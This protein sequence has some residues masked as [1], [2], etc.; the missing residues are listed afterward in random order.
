MRLCAS[1]FYARSVIRDRR[2]WTGH[3]IFSNASWVVIGAIGILYTVWAHGQGER[4]DAPSRSLG[5]VL[6]IV[7]ILTVLAWLGGY[8]EMQAASR[9]SR[10]NLLTLRLIDVAPNN[11]LFDRLHPDPRVVRTRARLLIDH[12]ILE[13][14]TVGHWVRDKISAPD[15]G[16][17]GRFRVVKQGEQE[18]QVSGWARLPGEGRPADWV[19]LSRASKQ[20]E[21]Q[22]VAGLMVTRDR[23]DIEKELENPRLLISGFMQKL[24]YEVTE[25]DE[26][27]MFAVDEQN[28]RLY[29]AGS[30]RTGE[31]MLRVSVDAAL[32]AGI[33]KASGSFDPMGWSVGARRSFPRP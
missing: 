18:I 26:F 9:R 11:P 12:Q 7:S 29:C 13:V 25:S 6:G 21:A 28:Q 20:H 24:R 1:V 27:R 3:S 19:L 10:L 2:G 30:A 4:R 17:G 32:R 16:G 14:D 23:P 33:F 31:R 8:A 22:V 15:G 5:L